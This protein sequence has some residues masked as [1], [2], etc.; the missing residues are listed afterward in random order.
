MMVYDR[1]FN[2][3]W[4]FSNLYNNIVLIYHPYDMQVKCHGYM[5]SS[6][7]IITAKHCLDENIIIV[8]Q[9]TQLPFLWTTIIT[10]HDLALIKTKEVSLIM[11][12]TAWF[13]KGD[14]AILSLNQSILSMTIWSWFIENHMIVV[15]ISSLPGQS[16]SPVFDKWWSLVGLVSSTNIQDHRTI[17][18]PWSGSFTK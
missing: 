9:N 12:K 11:T 4:S 3:I 15:N 5:I 1:H 10:G 2:Q 6:W 18:E 17:I 7:S 8:H 13:T 16:W 14:L